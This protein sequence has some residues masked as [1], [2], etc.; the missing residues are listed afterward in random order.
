MSITFHVFLRRDRTPSAA[1]WSEAIRAAGFAV[2]LPADFDPAT[3]SG[4]LPCPDDLTGFELYRDP[5]S[6]RAF[7]IG[8]DGST[9]VGDRNTAMTF[10][11]SGRDSDLVAAT[12]AAATLA[13]MSDGV[14]FD[15]EAGHFIA[16]D[17]A[18]AWAR[19][20]RYEPIAIYRHR[21]SRRKARLRP[22]TVIRLLIIIA[23]AIAAFQLLQR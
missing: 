17:Q 14:L 21:S 18:L 15:T 10:R 13:S 11:F 7:E 1:A 16:A 19:N 2:Q 8:P 6:E 9:A 12:A 5:F 23:L 22:A 20:E 3:H 4:Y